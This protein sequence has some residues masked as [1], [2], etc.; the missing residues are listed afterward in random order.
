MIK[1]NEED[2]LKGRSI[3]LSPAAGNG[4]VLQQVLSQGTKIKETLLKKI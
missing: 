1:L 4:S 3:M 2:T